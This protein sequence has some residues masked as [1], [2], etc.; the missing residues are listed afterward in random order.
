MI[1][2]NV[3]EYS[4]KLKE[5]NVDHYVVEHP[6]FKEVEDVL[7][8]CKL[9]FEN[10]ASTLIFKVDYGYIAVIRRDDCKVNLEKLKKAAK[11]TLLT[12]ATN[13]EFSSLT[14][15]EPG[16]ARIY[17]P[18]V[19]K[20]FLDKKIFE[21]KYVQA[22]SGSF[23]S[24]IN[25]KTSDLINLPNSTIVDVGFI[26]SAS[27]SILKSHYSILTGI[28]PSGSGEVHIGNYL[29]AVVPFLE[30]QKQADK[31]YF[32]IA[33]LHA[34]TTIQKRDEMQRNVENLVLS[35]LAFGIDT[36]KVVFYRQSDIPQH[37]ELQSILNNIT[38]LSL[39]KRAHAYKDKLQKGTNPEDINMGLFSY[40]ILMAADILLYDPDYVPVGDD[41]K[42]HIE[43]TRDV[44]GFFN[45]TYGKTF[46]LPDI[47]NMKESARL[48]GTDGKRKMSK[49]LN[50]YI[51]VFAEEKIIRKQ[52]MSCFTDPNRIKATDPGRVDGNPIFTYHRLLNDDKKEVKDLENRY[53]K[54][55]V[56][57]VEV[58]EKL[59]QAI[60]TKFKKERELYSQLK[61]NPERIKMILQSGAA[62]ARLQA[63]KKMMEVR[64]KIGITNKYSSFSYE[65]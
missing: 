38:P 27:D 42:Q 25:Y 40:P 39:I 2:L 37:T 23:T 13:K 50:N 18:Q 47:F 51:A 44:G 4:N 1:E 24:S 21:K 9:T 56:A 55:T 63:S 62:K 8:Y 17:I 61:T 16:S 49:S 58:K 30:L 6:Y 14:G 5:L 60:L 20:T 31:V 10:G 32:F 33:D 12:M 52:V 29:G 34:L 65:K 15:L 19:V 53:E 28:T 59:F 7:N 45:K 54:G 3:K 41:Q 35:Y 64:E 48:I 43:I 36:N 26:K 22:G 11:T 46:N 57:D